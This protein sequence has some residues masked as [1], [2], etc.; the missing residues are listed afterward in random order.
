M[1]N[2]KHHRDEA[3]HLETPDDHRRYYDDWAGSYEQDFVEASGYAYPERIAA[4]FRRIA[5]QL[6]GRIA[7]IGCG[8]GVVG[9]ALRQNGITAPLDGLDISQGM[10]DIA[11][12]KNA[13]DSLYCAD[14][15]DEK[16]FP[17]SR[18]AAMISS[19]TFTHGH[20]GPEALANLFRLA[21]P[22]CF[23]L[24]GINAMHFE[25]SAFA[26]AFDLWQAEGMISGLDWHMLEIYADPDKADTS[27]LMARV[28]AFTIIQGET[29]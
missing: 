6:N 23:A 17:A 16:T 18:Y 9:A 19:G 28:A 2:N 26:P 1:G 8:T 12:E 4:L 15:T 13:Y 5:P 3:Y 7:D 25:E 22:G 11:T 24:I 29:E 10:L 21:T 27:S 20:L 14:L